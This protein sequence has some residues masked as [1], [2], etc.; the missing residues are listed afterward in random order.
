MVHVYINQN[1]KTSHMLELPGSMRLA[2]N[3]RILNHKSDI[4]SIGVT[5]IELW[6]GCIF[7]KVLMILIL[8]VVKY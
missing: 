6:T 3:G 7:K 8:F 2:R 4:Y 5:L 1:N